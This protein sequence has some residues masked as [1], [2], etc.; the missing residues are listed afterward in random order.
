MLM[1]DVMA[2]PHLAHSRAL[3]PSYRPEL[4]PTDPASLPSGAQADKDLIRRWLALVSREYPPAL[5][6]RNHLKQASSFFSDKS[7]GA[8]R[9]YPMQGPCQGGS[10]GA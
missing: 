9:V 5:P 8:A 1:I 7:P 3:P 4:D 2:R 10:T 6:S